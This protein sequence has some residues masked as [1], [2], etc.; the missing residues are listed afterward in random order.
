[1]RT[2]C[3]ATLAVALGVIVHA[4]GNKWN[5]PYTKGVK[6]FEQ[7]KY[8]EAVSQLER[9]VAA[10]PKAGPNKIIEGVFRTD[11][12]PYYYLALSY[13]ELRQY[14]KAQQNLDKARATQTRQQAARITEAESKIKV[15]LNTGGG[16]GGGGGGTTPPRNAQFDNGV[17]QAE[18]LLSSRQYADALRQFDALRAMDANEYGKA[19]L[20]A[21][22][23]E[24]ARGVANDLAGAAR[25]AL[26][27]GRFSEARAKTQQ[28]DQ[29]SPGLK[30]VGDVV[31]EIR[32]RDEEYQ[33]SKAAANSE[34]AAGRFVGARD[35][36]QNARIANPEQFAADGLGPRLE[37][38]IARANA[39]G[40]GRG[41]AGGGPTGGGAGGGGGVDPKVLEGQ[42]LAKN[43]ADLLGRGNFAEADAA[44]AAA[45][46]ADPTNREA[47][48]AIARSSRF[49]ELRDEAA[50]LERSKNAAAAQK[51]LADARTLDARRFE[52]EGLSSVLERLA[53]SLGD[54]PAKTALHQGLLALLNGRAQD[55]IAILEPAVAKGGKTAPLHAYLGVAYATSALSAPKAEDQTRLRDKAVEQFRLAAA[56][57]PGYQL[58]NRIVSPAIIDIYKKSAQR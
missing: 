56:A 7:Q 49:R 16:G 8:D 26:D 37:D 52:A 29:I 40:R 2:A 53:K 28:A 24:A 12:F 38:M 51:L 23:E 34:A 54:D 31:A 42:R 36:F 57:E 4:Q 50:R 9:A 39:A 21:K 45:L 20:A 27:A 41:G 18:T 46:K 3:I 5:E 13:I 15:A 30:S 55:S 11:Y 14:D 19:G 44:Y 48:D 33:R 32:R 22:R 17:R 58:S 6:A 10:D 25:S 47:Q 1:M 43:A 35:N